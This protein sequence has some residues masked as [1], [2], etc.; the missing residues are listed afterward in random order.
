MRSINQP[1]DLADID[2]IHEI[3]ADL[4]K[5]GRE[6]IAAKNLDLR[7]VEV[8]NTV[9]M[10][11]VGQTHVLYIALPDATPGRHTRQSLFEA[12]CLA[13]FHVEMPDIRAHV[14]N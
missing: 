13:R 4:A 10:Q 8:R 12:A 11:F 5:K 2:R 7:G 3:L 1:L 6:L 14:I 9:D